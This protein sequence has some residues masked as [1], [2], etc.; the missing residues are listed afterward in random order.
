MANRVP[1][2]DKIMAFVRHA[3]SETAN[4]NEAR[5]AAM[6]ACEAIYR[7]PAV[8]SGQ[9]VAD[10]GED[11]EAPPYRSKGGKS[12]IHPKAK[13]FMEWESFK[14]EH[15]ISLI[16]AR[17]YGLCVACGEPFEKGAAILE[18]RDVGAT[19]AACHE[20]W[21]EYDYT[22]VTLPGPDDIPF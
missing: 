12:D 20:W 15:G 5:N 1:L 17:R 2:S 18:Q 7:H 11:V 4:E 14:A 22:G 6:K 3:V 8:L 9:E 19:H 16:R 13:A 21:K 10:E